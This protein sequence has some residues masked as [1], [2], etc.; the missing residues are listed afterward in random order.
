[1]WEAIFGGTHRLIFKDPELIASHGVIS[2]DHQIVFEILTKH[3]KIFSSSTSSA[4]F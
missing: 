4:H 3:K 1:M 2:E